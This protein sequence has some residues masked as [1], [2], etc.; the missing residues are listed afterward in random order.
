MPLIW[1]TIPAGTSTHSAKVPK[2]W[3]RPCKDC[4]KSAAG[5]RLSPRIEGT[6]TYRY[7]MTKLGRVAISTFEHF[8]ELT[9][10]PALARSD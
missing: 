2:E 5:S 8:T 3:R 9:I 4:A 10:A 1:A 6:C 7:Y